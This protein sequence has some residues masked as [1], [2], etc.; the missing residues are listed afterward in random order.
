MYKEKLFSKPTRIILGK[1]NQYDKNNFAALITEEN[2]SFFQNDLCGEVKYPTTIIE[3]DASNNYKQKRIDSELAGVT[4]RPSCELFR[5]CESGEYCKKCDSKH[6]SLFRGLIKGDLPQKLQDR[7][8][9]KEYIDNTYSKCYEKAPEIQKIEMENEDRYYI[10][11]DCPILGYRELVFPIMYE[12]IIL[13]VLFV[14]QIK[15]E[16][17]VNS[18]LKHKENFFKEYPN[19]FDEYIDNTITNYNEQNNTKINKERYKKEIQSHIIDKGNRF[20]PNK[21]FPV[22]HN[23]EKGIL[24]VLENDIISE[25][26]YDELKKKICK[27]LEKLEERVI[28]E[29]LIRKERY[30]RDAIDKMIEKFE[31]KTAKIVEDANEIYIINLWENVEGEMK[32]FVSEFGLRYI[33]IY[34]PDTVEKNAENY[35]KLKLVVKA[36]ADDYKVKKDKE[37][38]F[39][40][41]ELPD[42]CF[43]K[44]MS[45][46][47]NK[48]LFEGLEDMHKDHFDDK[49]ILFFPVPYNKKSSSVVVIKY[50]DTQNHQS[51]LVQEKIKEML[52]RSMLWFTAIIFSNLLAISENITQNKLFKQNENTTRTLRMYRHEI[53]H[54]SLALRNINKKYFGNHEKTSYFS[55]E[56]LKMVYEDIDSL[57]NL[58]NYMS[59]NTQIFTQQYGKLHKSSFSV[60]KELIYKWEQIYKLENEAKCKYFTYRHPDVSIEI[61]SDKF[62]LEQIVYNLINNAVKYSFWGTNIDID[63]RE[64]SEYN[65]R[66]ILSVT[67]YGV[68]IDETDTIYDLFYRSPNVEYYEHF[69]GS[70]IGLYIAKQAALALDASISHKCEFVSKYN[71]PLLQTY[72]DMELDYYVDEYGVV[73][74][75]KDVV[76]EIERLKKEKIYNK[77]ISNN[78]NVSKLARSR[79]LQTI[80]MPTYKVRFEV[81]L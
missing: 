3:F 63:F 64:E 78:I 54:L 67:D 29:S 9:K 34:G 49:I 69:E 65:D 4:L 41:D 42:E 10:E 47:D 27:Q 80:T 48:N 26:Q 5:K 76:D 11:Y 16:N 25:T 21:Q 18:I 43:I 32:K 66:Y 31:E 35:N 81:V 6:A 73:V 44:P 52:C 14:G 58:F 45:S 30:I 1:D 70:G 59:G 23:I 20:V 55:K 37:G 2:L 79:V 62:L 51:Q 71:I 17:K 60:F 8:D 38:C 15:L 22:H 28:S 7:I 39:F 68:K 74:R 72:L 33:L 77:V 56:K 50:Q 19:I 12:D 46:I 57:L 24:N 75:G 36:Y 53:S 61:F 40:L 13:G